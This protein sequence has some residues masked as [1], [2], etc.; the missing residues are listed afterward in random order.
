[1]TL[2]RTLLA[3][4]WRGRPQRAYNVSDDSEMKM[5]DYFDLAA[6]LYGLARPPRIARMR[7]TVD[8]ARELTPRQRQALHAVVDHCTVHNTLRQPPEIEIRIHDEQP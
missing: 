4:L 8:P 1:M 5:G 7:L 6:D 3:A 2:A